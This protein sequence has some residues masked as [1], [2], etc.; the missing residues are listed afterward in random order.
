MY[1]VGFGDCFLLAF[2]YTGGAS[3][4]V[5][6]DFGTTAYPRAREHALLRPI[7]EDIARRT[8]GKL[9]AVVA[10]HRHRD[11]IGG[12]SPFPRASAP[13]AVVAALKPE[14]I[15][16]PWTENPALG[17][18]ARYPAPF[19]RFALS[20]APRAEWLEVAR[21]NLAN[22]PAIRLLETMPGEHRYV[23]AGWRSGLGDLLPGVRVDVLGPLSPRQ[24]RRSNV[25]RFWASE[26]ASLAPG[27]PLFPGFA[28][29]RRWPLDTRWLLN[30]I[31]DF[32]SDRAL[33]LTRAYDSDINN[34]SV[35]L[36]F[37]ALGHTLLFPGDAETESWAGILA[38]R[39]N[40]KIV[41]ATTL[42]KTSH[43]G[44]ANGTPAALWEAL[45]RTFT[46]L[47]STQGGVYGQNVPCAD[48]LSRMRARSR[49]IDSREYPR[50]SSVAVELIAGKA[51]RKLDG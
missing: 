3:R 11:H 2:R 49:V 18:D 8:G 22:R 5:L 24:A 39:G 1:A 42:L 26:M 10:T 4:H 36:A 16:Q 6:I 41:G 45:P 34:T 17:E 48:L 50:G 40:A 31:Q 32:H 46:A 30:R 15:V 13:G 44:S 7:A 37:R 14:L 47:L 29:M 21:N 51:P 19:P 33:E 38:R 9:A 27:K 25:A 43:H 20:A 12:F 23:Y 28:A 35:V